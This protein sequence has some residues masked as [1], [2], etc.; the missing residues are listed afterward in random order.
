MNF[1]HPVLTAEEELAVTSKLRGPR[2]SK[3]RDKLIKHNLKLV[4]NIVKNYARSAAGKAIGREDLEGSGLVGLVEAAYK[5]DHAAGVRFSTYATYWI[6][7]EII[8]TIKESTLLRVPLGTNYLSQ[9]FRVRKAELERGG[10]RP[11]FEEVAVSLGVKE[12]K[13]D[14][15]RAAVDATGSFGVSISQE[16]FDLVEAGVG[17]TA[18]QAPDLEVPAGNLDDDGK[19]AVYGLLESIG[20]RDRTMLELRYGMVGEPLTLE[21]TADLF[22]LTKES[23]RVVERRSIRRFLEANRGLEG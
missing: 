10:R 18:W 22:G 19:R 9:Q 3:A 21:E 8:K 15:L 16:G 20:Q 2:A 4:R 17:S 1:N 23:I 5:F 13:F 11:T 14:L 7:R 6:K 12:K